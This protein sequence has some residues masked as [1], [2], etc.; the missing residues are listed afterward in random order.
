MPRR[1]DRPAHHVRSE[2]YAWTE[3]G[4]Q[5]AGGLARRLHRHACELSEP[6]REEWE[7]LDPDQRERIL[8]ML[9]E[10]RWT[11]E[12]PA[13]RELP[14]EHLPVTGP[15]VDQLAADVQTGLHER[16]LVRRAL[17]ELL[18]RPRDRWAA[19]VERANRRFS[20]RLM[21]EL[22]LDECRER[23]RNHP[24]DAEALAGLVPAVLQRIPGSEGEPWRTALAALATALRANALRVAGDLP[25]ADRLLAVLSHDLAREPVRDLA[26]LGEL[27]SLEA[28]LR[29]GQRRLAEAERLLDRAALLYGYAGDVTGEA[30]TL[31]QHA[32]LLQTAGRPE[33]IV[34]L[35]GRA[36]GAL[37]PRTHPYLFLCT[38]AGR[39]N[40]LCDL[41]RA[42]EAAVLLE[43]HV[44][45]FESSEDI[46]S[47]A[48]LRALEGRVASGQGRHEDA[49]RFLSDCIEAFLEFGRGYDAALVALHL[50]EVY[51]ATGNMAALEELAV[52]LLRA[53]RSRQI[54]REM[55]ATLRL[56]SQA[57]KSRSVTLA[58]LSDLRQRLLDAHHTVHA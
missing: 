52:S 24:R 16:R 28:S 15:E 32:N 7:R 18:K 10:L 30:R 27:A 39:V 31:I 4:L 54:E 1:D 44:D 56:L 47:G 46:Y 8:A 41:E 11:D 19:R 25:E 51:V 5:S 2:D 42:D 33:S 50:A 26:V 43:A 34:D 14:E 20:S 9:S 53:F 21:A 58:L 38:V 23:V 48:M 49:V 3:D 36:A 40:A 6:W 37:H 35:L 13:A 45:L 17:A 57:A 22:M 12:D 29:I 55:L